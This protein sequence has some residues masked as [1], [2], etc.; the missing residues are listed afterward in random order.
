M[1]K[2]LLAVALGLLTT[3]AVTATVVSTGNKKE[4]AKKETTEKVE[5]K[6]KKSKCSRASFASCW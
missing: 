6:A 1:K 2:Y 5:K 4:P 3:A